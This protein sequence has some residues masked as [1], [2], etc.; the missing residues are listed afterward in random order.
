MNVFLL[1]NPSFQGLFLTHITLG[2][3]DQPPAYLTG[4]PPV[5]SFIPEPS[6]LVLFGCAGVLGWLFSFRGRK[7]HLGHD[8]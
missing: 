4:L 1:D 2:G 7:G 3:G 8:W 6:T 5:M